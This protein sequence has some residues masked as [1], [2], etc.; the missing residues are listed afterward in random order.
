MRFRFGG[1]QG[2]LLG[3]FLFESYAKLPKGIQ[4]TVRRGNVVYNMIGARQLLGGRG[5]FL[6]ER[7]QKEPT[8]VFYY[9]WVC[10]CDFC[11]SH[12]GI[13]GSEMRLPV[14]MSLV[15]RQRLPSF[16]PLHDRLA[17]EI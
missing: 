16:D 10:S 9:I 7:M 17:I 13:W 1:G 12:F 4:D 5:S 15:A 3:F 2:D 14:F 8:F 11:T 6:L